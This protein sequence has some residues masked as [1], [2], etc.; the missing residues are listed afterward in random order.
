M[1]GQLSVLRH[2]RYEICL[3]LRNL[4]AP[5][6]NNRPLA[7]QGMRG[8]QKKFL[9]NES[10]KKRY[11]EFIEDLFV[12][13]HAS[14]VPGDEVVRNDGFLWYLPH[15]S[16]VH[17]H[18]D[19]LRVVLD[20]SAKFA[21]TSLNDHLLSGPDLTNDLIGVSLKF[22]DGRVAFISDIQCMFYQVRVPVEQRDL[23]RFLWWPGGDV[24]NELIKCRMHTHIFG[25]TSSPAVA[26]YALRKT[27]LDN[28]T[29]FSMEAVET[30]RYS[31]Y[32]DDCLKSVSTVEEGLRLSSELRA[33][34]QKGGFRLTKW[35]SNS[36]ELLSTGPEAD[37]SKNVKDIDLDCEAL[38]A[39]KALGVV[40]AVET[41]TLGFHVTAAQK[42]VTRRGILSTVSALYD[43]LGMAAPF[44]LISKMIVQQS[45]H[46]K[47][48]WDELVPDNLRDKWESWMRELPI[49]DG[50]P[51][52]GASSRRVLVRLNL[53]SCITSLTQVRSVMVVLLIY[54]WW[55]STSTFTAP[56]F[57]GRTELLL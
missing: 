35:V 30:V 44:V 49:L 7:L 20:A 37:R 12:K 40:W 39:E 5:L 33:L 42:P 48:S 25:A 13:G 2:G 43:P 6:P 41:G 29:D 31:F 14:K 57:S 16:V 9:A 19:K 17:P 46:L 28:A 56:S 18:K 34:T 32:G 54:D 24:T 27:A 50:Y 52:S 15:H 47:L 21:G 10:Y 3:P 4:S 53:L 26:S 36:H 1:V 23:L 51:L 45:C 38:P 55:M 8:L 22:R 11:T